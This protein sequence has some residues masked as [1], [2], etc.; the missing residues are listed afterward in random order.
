MFS[1]KQLKILAFPYTSYSALICD[2]AI[3]SGKTRIM[4]VAYIDWAMRSLS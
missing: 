4:T 1:E 2:G 3:R